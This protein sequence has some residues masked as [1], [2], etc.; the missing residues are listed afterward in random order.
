ML[1]STLHPQFVHTLV[2]QCFN[3]ESSPVCDHTQKLS[4]GTLVDED[5]RK[6]VSE[7]VRKEQAAQVGIQVSGV[8]H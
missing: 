8:T 4:K 1:S 5:I 3:S 2:L 6:T 7:N